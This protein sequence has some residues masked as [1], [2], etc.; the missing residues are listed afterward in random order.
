MPLQ[1]RKA[2][3][4]LRL[5]PLRA[6]QAPV[7][8]YLVFS[9][10]DFPSF[11]K[12]APE[13]VELKAEG[14]FFRP[15]D[16]FQASPAI[17]DPAFLLDSCVAAPSE[18]SLHA[19][20]SRV[21]DLAKPI[22]HPDGRGPLTSH[23][24]GKSPRPRGIRMASPPVELL[25]ETV[26]SQV[27]VAAATT[28][29]RAKHATRED[30]QALLATLPR[31]SMPATVLRNLED[32]LEVVRRKTMR[33]A[34]PRDSIIVAKERRK[35]KHF[36]M[37]GTEI[38]LC[39]TPGTVGFQSVTFVDNLDPVSQARQDIYEDVE[40]AITPDNYRGSM[41]EFGIAVEVPGVW[42]HFGDRRNGWNQAYHVMAH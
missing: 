21:P 40:D 41:A 15:A 14:F 36:S 27:S 20:D 31:K 35:A 10:I 38:P 7:I 16:A 5:L 4:K 13:M 6:T 32:K 24:V 33:L 18:H 37:G 9:P 12:Y 23:P 42:G 19:K 2:V 17:P 39:L 29:I 28:T 30:F 3:R 26:A 34:L 8:P 11:A 25:S 22:V 1:R